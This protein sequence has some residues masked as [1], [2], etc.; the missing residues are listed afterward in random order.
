M[1][2]TMPSGA[3]RMNAEGTNVGGGGPP[4][5]S[6]PLSGSRYGDREPAARETGHLQKRAAI[7]HHRH[8]QES[9]AVETAANVTICVAHE[10]LALPYNPRRG[11][12]L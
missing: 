2:V 12:R 5:A 4:W 1:I 9:Y 11:V 3:T 10:V 8:E 6:T 7:D